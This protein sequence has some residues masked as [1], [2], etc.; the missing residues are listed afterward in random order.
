MNPYDQY[1]ENSVLTASPLELVTMLYRC[2]LHGIS[3]ARRCLAAGDIEGRVRPVNRAFDAVT[4]LSLSLDHANG[5]ELS[6]SLNDLYAYITRQIVLGHTNQID[7]PF[8]EAEK[9]LATMMESWQ[10]IAT[11]EYSSTAAA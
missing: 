8:A 6:R 10:K 7:E 1:L 2:A 4:E 9:L 11:P 5:G 3:D